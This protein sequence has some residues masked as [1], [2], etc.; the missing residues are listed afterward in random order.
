M[1]KLVTLLTECFYTSQWLD[2]LQ[3]YPQIVNLLKN[4]MFSV[5]SANFSN[6]HEMLLIFKRAFTNSPKKIP[7]SLLIFVIKVYNLLLRHNYTI[8]LH[9]LINHNVYYSQSLYSFHLFLRVFH[10]KNT[11]QILL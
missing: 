1:I 4:S 5:Y 9:N 6:S 7:F 11:F 3:K 8:L 2:V 10:N